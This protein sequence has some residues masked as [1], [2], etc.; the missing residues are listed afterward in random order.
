MIYLILEKNDYRMIFTNFKSK[1]ADIREQFSFAFIEAFERKDF[2]L[3]ATLAQ[4]L[5]FFKA[6][7]YTLP[8]YI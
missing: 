4:S 8:I 2:S 6:F 5:H 3:K 7:I 1:S